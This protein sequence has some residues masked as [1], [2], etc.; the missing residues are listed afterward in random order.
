MQENPK[1][2]ILGKNSDNANSWLNKGASYTDTH[3]GST[4]LLTMVRAAIDHVHSIND[5]TYNARL[6]KMFL[7]ETDKNYRKTRI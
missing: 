5:E 6:V 4:E 2:W 3:W 1:K 7:G